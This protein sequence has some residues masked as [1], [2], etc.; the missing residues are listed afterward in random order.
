MYKWAKIFQDF[1]KSQM[2]IGEL[3]EAINNETWAFN[4]DY[5]PAQRKAESLNKV[6]IEFE[7]RPF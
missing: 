6:I 1:H 7:E 5:S 4:N 3:E 2:T